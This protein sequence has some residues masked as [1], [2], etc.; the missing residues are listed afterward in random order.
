MT[1]ELFWLA[2]TAIF[3]G[4]FWVPY[5]LDRTAVRGLLPAMGN[6]SP[7]DKPQSAWAQR[8]MKAH[9]NAIENLAVMAVLVLVAN[10]AKVTSD[11]TVFAVQLYFWARMAHFL[12]YAVGIPVLRTLAFATA[13]VGQAIMAL[14]LIGWL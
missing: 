7:N 12:I 1:T 3:T 11:L 13:F 6:P 2:L 10:A 9:A 5:I 14:A 4:L 8:M